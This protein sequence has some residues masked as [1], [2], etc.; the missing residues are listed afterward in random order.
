MKS[1]VH[2]VLADHAL[3]VA[4]TD[5]ELLAAQPSQGSIPETGEVVVPV[6][7]PSTVRAEDAGQAVEQRGRPRAAPAGEG[8][9]LASTDVDVDTRQGACRPVGEVDAVRSQEQLI[10]GARVRG[11]GHPSGRTLHAGVVHAGTLC[12]PRKRCHV[13]QQAGYRLNSLRSEQLSG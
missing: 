4:A 13:G 10:G 6:D 8:D 1:Q 7:D 3:R 12:H 9:D 2:A 11:G 5:A